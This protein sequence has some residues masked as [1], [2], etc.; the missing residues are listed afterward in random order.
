MLP[1]SLHSET[2]SVQVVSLRNLQGWW[3]ACPLCLLS[4]ISM[5]LEPLTSSSLVSLCWQ[6]CPRRLRRILLADVLNFLLQEMVPE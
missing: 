6:T 5:L 3:F 2:D 4:Q 1:R